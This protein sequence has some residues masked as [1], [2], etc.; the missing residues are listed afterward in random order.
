MGYQYKAYRKRWYAAVVGS[1]H[2]H[3]NERFEKLMEEKKIEYHKDRVNRYF[4]KV[5]LNTAKH[6]DMLDWIHIVKIMK[7]G[8]YIIKRIEG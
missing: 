7:R 2:N 4:I 5:D 3:D 6:L 8:S 1:R